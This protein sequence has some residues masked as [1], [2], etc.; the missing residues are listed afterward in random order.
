MSN[1]LIEIQAMINPSNTELDTILKKNACIRRLLV[2]LS[3]S[4]GAI[5]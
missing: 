3:P 4:S 5:K 2:G 1:V